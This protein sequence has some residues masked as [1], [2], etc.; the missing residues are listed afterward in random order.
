MTFTA[1]LDDCCRASRRL[2]DTRSPRSIS[3]R[4]CVRFE[5]LKLAGTTLVADGGCAMQLRARGVP[6][7]TELANL[8]PA[9]QIEALAREYAAVGARILSTNTFLANRLHFE[10]LGVAEHVEA[11][12]RL[13]A[14]LARRVADEMEAWVAGVIGPSGRILAIGESGA[15]DARSAFEEQAAALAAGGA[16][17]LV[18]ETFSE[19][20]EAEIALAAARNATELPV[21]ACM[22]FDSGPQRTRTAMGV[23]ASAAAAALSAAGAAGVGINCGAGIAHALP[24][25][26][27]LRANSSGL[28]WVK[29]SVGLPDLSE[30]RPVYRQSPEEFGGFIPT[31]LDAGADIIG[32]CCGSGPEH[33]KRVAA[34][35]AG[36]GRHVSH[37]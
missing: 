14:A 33:I 13:G 34:I 36:R 37:P 11:V 32:G 35:V 5:P 9:P 1:P 3:V 27:A 15:S 7:P 29:P 24:A 8:L 26:V 6:A 18:L 31:L 30:G 2:S 10:R 21:I 19:L 17:L 4:G 25:V 20:A 23:E 12:N 28:L 16:D 22:S